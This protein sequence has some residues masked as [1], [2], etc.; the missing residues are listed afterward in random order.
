MG[1]EPHDLGT[2][3]LSDHADPPVAFQCGSSSLGPASASVAGLA[4]RGCGSP[5]KTECRRAPVPVGGDQCDGCCRSGTSC[6]AVLLPRTRVLLELVGSGPARSFARRS[7][8]G[9]R[10]ARALRASRCRRPSAR[11][12]ASVVFLRSAALNTFASQAAATTGTWLGPWRH[13]VPDHRGTPPLRSHPL[14]A[15]LSPHGQ[16]R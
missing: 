9:S 15:R 5:S 10:R 4:G 14:T 12:V 13:R 16:P 1:V 3:L 6:C 2:P 8:A 7:V 11:T